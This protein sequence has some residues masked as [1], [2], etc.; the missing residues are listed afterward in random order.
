MWSGLAVTH[1]PVGP[2]AAWTLRCAIFRNWHDA[3]NSF[4]GL[5]FGIEPAGT[6]IITGIGVAA[7]V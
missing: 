6:D 7:M 2:V 4:S 3:K 1:E 5:E